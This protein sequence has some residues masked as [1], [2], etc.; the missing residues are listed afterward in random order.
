M[1]ASS[2]FIENTIGM[3]REATAANCA[4]PGRVGN[5]VEISRESGDDVMLTGDLHGHRRNF[6]LIRRIAALEA[7]SRRHLVIQEVCHGGPTYPQNGGC[8]SHTIL[9]D[10]ARLKVHYPD[11]VHFLLGN[12]ELAELTDYP[13]QKNRQM[14]NVMFRLGLEQMYGAATERVHQALLEFLRSCPLAV[15][16]AGGVFVC[17]SIPEG[18]DERPFDTT[19]FSR[20]LDPL[21]FYERG[22]IFQLVWGRDHRPENARAFAELMGATVL[23]HGHEPCSEGYAVPNPHQVIIDCC[24]DLACYIILST[25]RDWT[26]AEVVERI[27]R[28]A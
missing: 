24:H 28:L 25:N 16:I 1:V 11:R 21:E 13:I 6:N 14:L 12:H 17:H 3:F 22:D 7:F 23:I 19:V 18:I 2:D 9:E 26:Q 10:V 8:M 20:P 27:Q 15:R 4:T 5:V